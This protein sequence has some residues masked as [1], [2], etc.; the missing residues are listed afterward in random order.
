MATAASTTSIRWL[1]Q[2]QNGTTKVLT[3]NVADFETLGAT[4]EQY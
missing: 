2:S 3:D 4:V 1:L